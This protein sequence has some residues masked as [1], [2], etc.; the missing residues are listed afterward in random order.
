MLFL[1]VYILVNVV[2]LYME[3]EDQA[4]RYVSEQ[5]EYTDENGVKRL[6]TFIHYVKNSNPSIR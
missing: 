4:G 6:E 3:T 2:E 1:S 5:R